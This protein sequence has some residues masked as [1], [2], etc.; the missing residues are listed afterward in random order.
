MHK[1]RFMTWQALPEVFVSTEHGWKHSLISCTQG[2]LT[3]QIRFIKRTH[4][5]LYPLPGCKTSGAILQ[6]EVKVRGEHLPIKIQLRTQITKN[7]IT[8][9][10]YQHGVPTK[11]FLERC[12]SPVSNMQ[13]ETP[14]SASFTI[15]LVSSRMFPACKNNRHMQKLT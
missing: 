11:V 6:F 7:I 15:P 8:D 5:E 9:E 3:S 1:P 14:K 2:N 4:L 13:A 12:R 10:T